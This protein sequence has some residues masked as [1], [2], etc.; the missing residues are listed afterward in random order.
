MS[1]PASKRTMNVDDKQAPLFTRRALLITLTLLVVFGLLLSLEGRVGW[2]KYGLGFW[3]DAWTHCTSQHFLDPYSLS[4]FLHGVI[5]YW[6]LRLLF[7]R[8]PLSWRVVAAIVIEMGWELLENSTL[9]I[10]H[11]RKNTASFDY[12]GDSIL[13][14]VG[15]VL[16]TIVGLYFASRFSWKAAVAAYIILELIALYLAR[17][18]LTLN[19]LMF[20]YP[21]EAIKQWQWG[22]AGMSPP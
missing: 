15:D 17:D 9:A 2:C 3:A 11:Y 12:A 7:P 10:E 22:A 8:A 16:S 13:N 20:I 1:M 4:H 5:F 14:S 19:V 21:F 18:N 6:A